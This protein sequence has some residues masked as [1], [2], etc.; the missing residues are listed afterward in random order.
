MQIK[1]V[2]P[3]WGCE[4]DTTEIFIDKVISSGY[5]G[6]EINLPETGKFTDNFIAEIKD[7]INDRPGFIF[8]VQQL[9]APQNQ[10]VDSYIK[11]MTKNLVKL[12]AYLTLVLI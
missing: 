4:N 2:C 7:I 12:A 6:I 1:Y 3:F 10:S 11:K 9:I 5:N 8:I